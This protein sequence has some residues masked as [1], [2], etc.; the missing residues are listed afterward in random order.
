MKNMRWLTT[1]AVV[2]VLGAVLLSTGCNSVLVGTWKATEEPKGEG[3]ALT[4][5]TFKDDGTYTAMAK[6]ADET[7]KLAGT[8]DFNGAKLKLKTPGKPDRD[9]GA[10]F[11]LGGTL[12]LRS[13]GQ[14]Q[15]L[16]KQ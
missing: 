2:C 8:Y 12:D 16:K 3:F 15:T 10:T 1:G 6:R 11:I 7:V 5:A 4:T 9:Y 14:K 13:D